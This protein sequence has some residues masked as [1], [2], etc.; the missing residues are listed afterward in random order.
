MI[1]FSL[2]YYN[3]SFSFFIPT[4]IIFYIQ[5]DYNYYTIDIRLWST[6]IIQIRGCQNLPFNLRSSRHRKKKSL[7]SNFRIRPL[8]AR[9]F[10]RLQTAFSSEIHHNLHD[11]VILVSNNYFVIIVFRLVVFWKRLGNIILLLF[12][13]LLCPYSP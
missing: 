7:W 10:G 3:I 6:I 9:G 2:L 13:V 12:G 11:F 4:I 8:S 5:F 1:F